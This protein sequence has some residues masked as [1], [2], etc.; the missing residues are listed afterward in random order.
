MNKFLETKNKEFC[1]GC[2]NCYNL[3][4][5]NCIKME[6]DYE[7]FMYPKV[8]ISRC[9]NCNKCSKVCP[10]DNENFDKNQ[11]KQVFCAWAK[12]SSIRKKGSS[13]GI[14][15]L[16]AYEVINNGGIVF[17]ATYD[18]NFK[19]V[20]NYA[21]NKEDVK[22]FFGSKYVQSEIGQSFNK[23][24]HFLLEG[25]TVLFSGVPCQVAALKEYL[26]KDYEKLILVEII[27]HGVPSPKLFSKYIDIIVKKNKSKLIDL[28]FRDKN[29]FHY[30]YGA[31]FIYENKIKLESYCTIPYYHG[32]LSG[33]LSRPICYSCKFSS[34][35]READ[36]T[37]GDFWG[38][39][40][41]FDNLELEKGVS[42]ISL[43]TNKGIK[44]F[45]TFRSKVEAIETTYEIAAKGNMNLLRPTPKPI[46]REGIY[47]KIYEGNFN[48][49]LKKNLLP[50][51]YL[52]HLI[53]RNIKNKNRTRI[54]SFFRKGE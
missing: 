50:K 15:P 49:N 23:V 22:K 11:N 53:T 51:S 44:I 1:C 46:K 31:K 34:E 17:G 9:I 33:E 30:P 54:K 28:K 42:V 14:F 41:F 13:G 18:K 7:G 36:I 29:E 24:L 38:A 48:S 47:E 16:I 43:N 10:V 52:F 45:N 6:S 21:D 25:K 8:D 3:C 32:F 27:C 4:P 37:L 35:I 39:E 26:R 40:K 20:H 5:T 12:D 2:E 19:V